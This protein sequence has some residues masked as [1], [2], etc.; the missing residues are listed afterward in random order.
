MC[1]RFTLTQSA[2]IIAQVFDLGN[3]PPFNPRYNIAPSQAIATILIKPD[4]TERQ[5]QMLHW[6]LIP[7]WAKDVKMGAKLINARAETLTEKPSFRTAFKKRRCL[8]IADGFY[9]WQQQDGKKQPFY[10]KLQDEQPFAFAGLW[11]HWESEREVIESCTILTTEA[12]QIMQPIHGRMPV[13]LS[14]KDYDLWLDPSVQK[15]DLLQP[16]LLPY[17]AEEMTAY[18]VSTRVNKPM[19]DSPE[20][21]Q[22]LVAE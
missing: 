6:G 20:C 12:N 21:I 3:I 2:E 17:S 11:E 9:E 8:I 7:R 14:S 22:E 4:D 15:S 1:G 18:P 13:I 5:L 19:N 10:F 16:L